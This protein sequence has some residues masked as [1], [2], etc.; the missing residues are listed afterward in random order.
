M[1]IKREILS[2]RRATVCATSSPRL[3]LP[4]DRED[5]AVMLRLME[6]SRQRCSELTEEK[7]SI[8]FF[9]M[10]N[11]ILIIVFFFKFRNELASA[12]RQITQIRLR[13]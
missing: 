10:S 3:L 2:S 9:I 7:S 12:Q 13:N 4:S 6:H 5:I 1:K 8:R 11:M